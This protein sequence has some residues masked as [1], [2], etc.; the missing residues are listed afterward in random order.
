MKVSSMAVVDVVVCPEVG[1]VFMSG[2]MVVVSLTR[3]ITV[4]VA[5]GRARRADKVEVAHWK[6]Q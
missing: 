5:V 1:I 6:I 2:S 4:V 3:A